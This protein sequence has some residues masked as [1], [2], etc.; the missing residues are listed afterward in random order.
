M[1]PVIWEVLDQER[2]ILVKLNRP[3]A[4]VLD[5][6]MIQALQKGL[7]A[8]LSRHTR[9]LVIGHEGPNFSFGASVEEHRAE[10]AAGMLA[11]FHGLFKFLEGTR[12]PLLCAVKG[13]CLGGGMELVSFCH[14]TFA[15]PAARFGQPEIN[16]GVFPPM[17][18]LI[19]GIRA[20]ELA[21]EL[22]LTGRIMKAEECVGLITQLTEE[23]EATAL[24][25]A[26]THFLGKSG[27]GL[28]HAVWANRWRVRDAMERVLPRLEAHY[29]DELMK[30][31]D[32]NEGIQS[33]L[34]KRKPQWR[35]E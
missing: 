34:E 5:K 20:P 32:A 17:A 8:R 12:V 19:L 30:T 16:L 4:N 28:R 35:D 10:E 29:L 6:N 13:H 27:S 31:H 22:N 7:E 14:F 15:H 18:S 26:R 21:D 2:I 23:P 24:E 9:A 33:F 3:K 11:T 1:E 25:F